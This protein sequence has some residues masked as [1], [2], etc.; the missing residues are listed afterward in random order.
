LKTHSHIVDDHPDHI[1]TGQGARLL[2]AADPARFGNLRHYIL[3]RYWADPRL[4]NPAV[5]EHWDT[6]TDATVSARAINGLRCYGA[7]APPDSYAIGYH[8]VYSDMFAPLLAATPKC[9]YHS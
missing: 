6:P 7:W 4:S 2:A 8:S 3:P 5:V 1:A 9:L